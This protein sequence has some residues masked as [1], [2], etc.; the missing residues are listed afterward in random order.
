MKCRC[1]FLHT[2]ATWQT[3]AEGNYITRPVKSSE[4]LPGT[5]FVEDLSQN[6]TASGIKLSTGS[7]LS[8]RF[9]FISPTGKLDQTHH[10]MDGGLKENSGAETAREILSVLFR[11]Y[12]QLSRSDTTWGKIKI[13]S[14]I[15]AQQHRCPEQTPFRRLP[16]FSN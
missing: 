1:Q 10:F 12:N 8:A 14:D 4:I 13:V 2:D 15:A 7:F 5:V 16:I 9:P 11:K 3:Q 6:D